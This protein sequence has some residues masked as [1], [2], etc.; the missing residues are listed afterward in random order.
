VASGEL[1]AR[2]C[3]GHHGPGP[4]R[5]EQ[6][7]TVVVIAQVQPAPAKAGVINTADRV[8]ELG[9]TAGSS[10]ATSSRPAPPTRS[11]RRLTTQAPGALP[12]GWRGAQ[13]GSI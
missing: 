11:R 7:N 10:A 9:P 13:R 12:K 2:Q 1:S 8:I 5:L 3:S 4:A 6:G